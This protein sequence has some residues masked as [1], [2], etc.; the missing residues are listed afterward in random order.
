MDIAEIN[1]HGLC[2]LLQCTEV[3]LENQ[4]PTMSESCD[5]V[6]NLVQAGDLVTET[7]ET[8]HLNKRH[9]GSN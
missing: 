4:N 6:A 8:T 5:L 7:L 1:D 3:R 2:H 9:P